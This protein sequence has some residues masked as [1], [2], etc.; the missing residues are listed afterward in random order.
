M[1]KGFIPS[2]KPTWRLRMF[3]RQS[4]KMGFT[5]IELLIVVAVI[6]ILAA[7]AIPSFNNY[8][9]RA[10]RA[11]GQAALMQLA[12]AEGKYR[13]NCTTYAYADSALAVSNS[14]LT[15][16]TQGTSGSTYNSPDSYYTV[17]VS[18]VTTTGYYGY[19]V[20]STG[21]PQSSDSPCADGTNFRI[22]QDGPDKSDANKKKCWGGS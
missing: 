10:R 1:V 2:F 12:E 20:P 5:L 8:M 9:M 19:V 22:T 18:G 15:T 11:D 4:L 6:G 3:D 14:T 16:C 7:I 13:A 21:S 17:N